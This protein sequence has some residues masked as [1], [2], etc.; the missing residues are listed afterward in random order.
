M[1]LKAWWRKTFGKDAKTFTDEEKVQSYVMAGTQMGDAV[2]YIY[3]GECV[4]F[5]ELLDKWEAAER[6]Y[7]DL[8]YRTLSI[9]DFTSYGGYGLNIEKLFRVPR[10]EGEPVV[11]HAAYYRQKYFRKMGRSSVIEEALKGNVAVGNYEVPTTDH[12]KVH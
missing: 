12:L 2:S 1:G 9:D 11:L 8:G 3:M 4:G 6:A 7:A 10:K 5:G